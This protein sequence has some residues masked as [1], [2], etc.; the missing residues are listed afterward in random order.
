MRSVQRANGKNLIGR[1]V[2]WW[3]VT[4]T[5]TYDGNVVTAA[6][7]ISNIVTFDRSWRR[8]AVNAC[9]LTISTYLCLRL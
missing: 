9:R 1:G 2:A 3:A 5:V 4:M 7:D 8:A 6:L